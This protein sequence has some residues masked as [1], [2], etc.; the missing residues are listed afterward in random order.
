MTPGYSVT[1]LLVGFLIGLT[2]MGG[3]SLMTPLLILLLGVK[4]TVAVGSD[5]A[6]AAVTKIVGAMS[7]HQQQTVNYGLAWRMA[8]G[9]VPG[10]LMGVG[11]VRGLQNHLGDEA[12]QIVGHVLGLMLVL[13][14]LALFWRCMPPSR[15][16]SPRLIAAP[17]DR[18]WW[19]AGSGVVL[20]FLVGVTSVG[21]GTLFG[22]LLLAVFGLSAREMVGTDLF[23]AALLTSAAAGAH[24]WAGNVDYSL[25]ANLLVGSIPGV[26][27]GSRL[28]ARMPEKALRPVLAGVLL[29]SGLKMI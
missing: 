9:S 22:M 12:Q 20:G 10:C 25:V 2:G 16:W 6:Y 5:L 8:V 24:V 18:I 4:P 1:G 15:Q 14:G 21:S 11:C 13:V 3:G 28:A 29:F 7:H 19:A 23:H 26:L 27:L 17:R